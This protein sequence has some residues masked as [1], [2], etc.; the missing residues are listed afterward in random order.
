MPRT[1]RINLPPLQLQSPGL[2]TP[3]PLVRPNIQIGKSITSKPDLYDGDQVKYIQWWQTVELY[4][5]RFEEEPSDRQ[6]VLIV[7]SYI[8]EQDA[9]GRWVDLYISQGLNTVCSFNDFADQLKKTF[10]PPNIQQNA[11]KCLL[12]L[13]QGKE[14]VEDFM[15]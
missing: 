7:L 6:K 8:K 2:F 12:A 1:P 10:Q 9:A 5:A 4:L 15:T 14:M 3:N 13:K 11:E